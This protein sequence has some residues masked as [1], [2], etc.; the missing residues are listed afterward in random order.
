MA[1]IEFIITFLNGEKSKAAEV[2]S[3][4]WSRDTRAACDGLRL[5]FLSESEPVEAVALE[6]YADG[7]CV[8]RGYADCQSF[9]D[10]RAFIYAR[11]SACLLVD[12][13]APQLTYNAPCVNTLFLVNAEDFGFKNGLKNYWVRADY[14]IG[15]GTSCYGAINS[16]VRAFCKNNIAVSPD[17]VL[18]V[19][20]GKKSYTVDKN[21]VLGLKKI[22]KRGEAVSRIDCKTDGEYNRHLKSTLLDKNGIRRSRKLSLSA[23]PEWQRSTLLSSVIEDSAR[24]YYSAELTVSGVVTAELCSP[25]I[26]DGLEG[27]RISSLV[28]L[29]NKNGVKT[30][31]GLSKELELGEVEYVAE[32]KN[33]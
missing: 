20:D 33:E 30:V 31:I 2:V 3:Y 7:K 15:R 28:T 21:A 23:V 8:F 1:E 18:Y 25:V 17:G 26:Y 16:F 6:A 12:N 10:G 4:E 24:E 9:S 19:P 22:I 5:V 13:E 27:Y 11:S 32:Q 29:G 14:P